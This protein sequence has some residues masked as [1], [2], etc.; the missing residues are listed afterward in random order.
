MLR[1]FARRRRSY[2]FGL[3]VWCPSSYTRAC[4]LYP[5]NVRLIIIYRYISKTIISKR[6][7]CSTGQNG[8][9]PLHNVYIGTHYMYIVSYIYFI[10]IFYRCV[11]REDSAGT[12]AHN[13][14]TTLGT[15]CLCVRIHTDTRTIGTRIIFY[16]LIRIFLFVVRVYIVVRYYTPD[17]CAR[18]AVYY[19]CDDNA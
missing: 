15:V 9:S 17:L 5:C 16:P 13:A 14:R 8:N 1:F 6:P 2:L 3:V 4:T 19:T 11:L 10:R 12:A 18:T 7:Y